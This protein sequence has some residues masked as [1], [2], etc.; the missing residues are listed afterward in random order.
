MCFLAS[1]CFPGEAHQD[2][3]PEFSTLFCLLVSFLGS[4]QWLPKCVLG[5]LKGT[6]GFPGGISDKGPTCQC[7]RYK[8]HGFNARSGRSPGGGHGGNP[9]YSCL[10]NP[11]DRGA[12][13]ATVHTVARESNTTQQQT[14]QGFLR[15]FQL[16]CKVKIIFGIIQTHSFWSLSLLYSQECPV[17]FPGTM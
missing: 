10:G 2:H 12:W 6:W 14:H 11:M 3:H 4:Q 16:M 1:S 13:Q 5:T 8:R 15:L 17:E 7:R 9:M